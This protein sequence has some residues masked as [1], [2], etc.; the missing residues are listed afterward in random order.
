MREKLTEDSYRILL[1]TLREA[2][3][4]EETEEEEEEPS[5]P[6]YEDTIPERSDEPS[7]NPDEIPLEDDIEKESEVIAEGQIPQDSDGVANGHFGD[8]EPNGV[9]DI[10]FQEGN[11]N[12]VSN[13]AQVAQSKMILLKQTL[14]PLCEKALIELLGSSSMFTR[15]SANIQPSF[16][17]NGNFTASGTLIYNCSFWIGID[18]PPEDIQTD[19]SYVM[20]TLAPIGENIRISECSIET[21]DG[22]LTIGFTV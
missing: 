9:I 6:D 11:W 2:D 22:N 10:E 19:A 18:V 3:E 15:V 20:N 16:D 8:L 12:Q 14:E 13:I 21:A 1:S 5:G 7:E 4:E 17:E